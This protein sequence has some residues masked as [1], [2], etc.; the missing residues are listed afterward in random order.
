MCSMCQYCGIVLKESKA[1]NKKLDNEM[2][3]KSDN[4]F[5]IR[6]CKFCGEKLMQEHMKWDSL[7]PYG[8]P[9]ISPTTSSLSSDDG[10]AYSYGK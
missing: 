8:S 7:S 6:P 4:K 5:L 1:S 3:L 10:S 9:M 2:A